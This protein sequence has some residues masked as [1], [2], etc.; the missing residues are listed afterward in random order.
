MLKIN[1]NVKIPR[2]R[3]INLKL[4]I[5]IMLKINYHAK[6]P[7]PPFFKGGGEKGN[8]NIKL[9]VLHFS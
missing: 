8:I 1:Y 9:Y 3:N 5:I 2:M 4:Y 7:Q 6:T